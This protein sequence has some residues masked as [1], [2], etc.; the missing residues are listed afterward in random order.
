MNKPII[1][2]VPTLITM[3]AL[4][5]LIPTPGLAAA[6]SPDSSFGRFGTQGIASLGGMSTRAMELLP[7]GKILVVGS[8]GPNLVIRRL[9][10]DGDSDPGFGSNGQVSLDLGDDDACGYYGDSPFTCGIAVQQDGRFVVVGEYS[11]GSNND[12]AVLRFLANGDLD[13]SFGIGG[14]VTVDFDSRGDYANDVAIQAD[15][16]IVI[17]GT[18]A[19][20]K[21]FNTSFDNRFGVAR[22][23]TNGSL[24]TSFSADGK[25]NVSFGDRQGSRYHE[26]NALAIQ[27]DGKIVLVGRG[28]DYPFSGGSDSDFGIA[29][30]NQDGSLDN[31]FS[32]DG[33]KRVGFGNAETA[34]DVKITPDG[35]IVV[36]GGASMGGDLGRQYAV[37]RLNSDGEIDNTFNGDGRLL[38]NQVADVE[39]ALLAVAL[40]ADGKILVAGT[41]DGDM[42]VMRYNSN[43]TLDSSFGTG[44]IVLADHGGVVGSAVAG[45]HQTAT[46]SGALIDIGYGLGFIYQGHIAVGGLVDGLD[47]GIL[48]LAP[49][50]AKCTVCGLVAENHYFRTVDLGYTEEAYGFA[51]Q[52]NGSMVLTGGESS[53][54]SG[55][56]GAR[57]KRK[58]AIFGD[59]YEIDT[60]FGVNGK[61][62]YR[63][64]FR[65]SARANA[66]YGAGIFV[67]GYRS[68]GNDDD[69]FLMKLENDSETWPGGVKF[70]N[71]IFADGFEN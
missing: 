28:V 56:L 37:A 61:I 47:F 14:L 64:K 50:G 6:G 68:N 22:L 5:I 45:E 41:H 9:R 51:V 17:I 36:V 44:G 55:V 70:E 40:Q 43:G 1:S 53:G 71:L 16:K 54:D 34:Y 48:I 35:K 20:E 52:D 59:G 2:V 57:F 15:G 58:R 38:L 12:F 26:G 63:S 29:R 67:A 42:L 4:A 62:N 10:Q 19:F 66:L 13:A 46:N 24:D 65:S 39:Q 31:S 3:I 11:V 8:N 60:T 23:N 18:A 32:G 7:D 25:Q 30:L 21:G 69:F 33:K 49:D 27:S